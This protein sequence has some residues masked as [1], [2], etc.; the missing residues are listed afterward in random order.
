MI[1]DFSRIWIFC[2]CFNHRNNSL[3]AQIFEVTCLQSSSVY[4]LPTA[5][6]KTLSSGDMNAFLPNPW[7]LFFIS[8]DWNGQFSSYHFRMDD[9][10]CCAR[11]RFYR[12]CYNRLLE[13]YL[14]RAFYRRS[15]DAI[16][17]SPSNPQ[18]RSPWK[19]I[20]SDS[21]VLA[22]SPKTNCAATK[23]IRSR[24]AWKQARTRS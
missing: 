10:E 22:R 8:H 6:T 17:D 3:R 2:G 19:I 11:Q 9:N 12:K 14:G 16:R 20:L 1:S 15:L 24:S 23:Q 18:S 21:I 13:T 4:F 5:A 7:R